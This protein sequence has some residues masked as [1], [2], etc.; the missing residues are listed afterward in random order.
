M[1]NNPLQ[2]YRFFSNQRS[3]GNIH[4]YAV[5][6][7]ELSTF[8]LYICILYNQKEILLNMHSALSALK[9]CI[10]CSLHKGL[11]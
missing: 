5:E 9:L 3:M 1:K 4:R 6:K 10:C 11:F 2:F 8:Y 7:F